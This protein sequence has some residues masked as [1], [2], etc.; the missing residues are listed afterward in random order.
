MLILLQP[1]IAVLLDPA[2]AAD[3]TYIRSLGF[4]GTLSAATVTDPGRVVFHGFVTIW[5]NIIDTSLF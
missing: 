3:A 2:A 5:L 1:L 4:M